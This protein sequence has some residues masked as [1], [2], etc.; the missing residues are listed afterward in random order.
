[1]D[2]EIRFPKG[3][4]NE[5]WDNLPKT[6]LGAFMASGLK[7]KEFIEG[8]SRSLAWPRKDRENAIMTNTSAGL[9]WATAMS[10]GMWKGAALVKDVPTKLSA[11]SNLVGRIQQFLE[12]TRTTMEE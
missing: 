6:V 7:R 11:G 12:A 5:L 2:K 4:G 8:W 1:M 10:S 3:F 9:L